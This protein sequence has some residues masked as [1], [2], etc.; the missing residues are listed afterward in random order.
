MADLDRSAR[1]LGHPPTDPRETR[2]ARRRP[3]LQPR[4]KTRPLQ[5]HPRRNQRDLEDGGRRLGAPAGLRRRPGGMVAGGQ[6]DCLQAE[7]ASLH[8]GALLRSGEADQPGGLAAPFGP[9]VESRRED[10]CL[11]LPV[12]SRQR[13]LP[14]AGRR[15]PAHQGL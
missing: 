14:G 5:L 11:C 8:T 10:H 1:R 12:G 9:G 3:G 6:V 2:R 15:G 7:R 13:D 4:R